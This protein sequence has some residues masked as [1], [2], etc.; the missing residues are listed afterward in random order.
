[1]RL[2]GPLAV[3]V[4]AVVAAAPAALAQSGAA[5]FSDEE[6]LTI[7]QAVIGQPVSDYAFDDASGGALNLAELRGK[8]VVV[9]MI[10]TSCYHICPMLTQRLADVADVAWEALGQDSFDVVT[11]GFDTA[12]DTP[13][14]MRAY[15]EQRGLLQPNWHFL[16]G[17]PETI[18]ALSKDL[19]FIFFSSPKGFDH[20]AQTTVLN[21][22]GEVY[23][24]VYGQDFTTPQLVEPLKELVFN[25]P[26]DASLVDGWLDT[27]RLFCTIYDPTTGRYKFDYSLFVGIFVGVLCLGAVATFLVKSW[28]DAI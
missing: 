26:Q 8:P 22:K 24:Q 18:D 27:V 16:S 10:Y 9:S 20:L 23:R 28:R 7:S 4:T 12:F 15:A 17:T 6:A 13:A 1:M 3:A 19:G 21:A 11:I 14:R 25:T 5:L 2:W